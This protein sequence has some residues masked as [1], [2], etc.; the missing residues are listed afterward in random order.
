MDFECFMLTETIKILKRFENLCIN[1]R[2]RSSV[3][4]A[5]DSGQTATLALSEVKMQ[6]SCEA[7]AA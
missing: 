1:C 3:L 7:R 2:D 4:S 5:E 6:V